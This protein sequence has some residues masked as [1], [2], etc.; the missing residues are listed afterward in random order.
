[1]END[2][3]ELFEELLG[4]FN[5]ALRY[6]GKNNNVC[7]FCKHDCGEGGTCKGR[8]DWTEC[9]PEWR[10]IVSVSADKGE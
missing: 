7:N 8:D 4:D 3:K 9:N 6:A 5:S 10:G 1:M 2:Y